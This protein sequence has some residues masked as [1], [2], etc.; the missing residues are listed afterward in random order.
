VSGQL[1][2]SRSTFFLLLGAVLALMVVVVV[3]LVRETASGARAGFAVRTQTSEPL[4]PELRPLTAEEE[5]FAE[6]LWPLHQ[7]TVEPAAGRLT[8]AGLA[9]SLDDHDASRFGA[10]L[11]P[12]RQIFHDTREKVAAIPVPS[13]LQWARD[14]YVELLNLYEQS[15]T[16]MLAVTRDGD[17]GHLIDAQHK[18]QRAAEEL[19]KVGDSLWPSEHKPN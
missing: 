5:T 1:A 14:R 17:E 2:L 18:S 10:Q 4:V 15:A 7:E 8:V 9:F 13:S 3:S 12:L 6:A 11:T 19:E 16:E